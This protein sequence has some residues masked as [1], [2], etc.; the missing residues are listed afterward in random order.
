[1]RT[2]QLAPVAAVLAFSLTGCFAPGLE[3]GED[4]ASATQADESTNSLTANSL[5]ANSLTANSLTANSLTANALTDPAARAV[6]KYIVGCAL[7]AGQSIDL[8]IGGT[9]YHYDGQLGLAPS[10]GVDQGSSG[11]DGENRSACD[12]KCIEAVSSCVL[13]R[14]NYLGQM[15]PISV[16][17]AGLTAAPSEASAYPNMD[18]TYYGNI[19]TSPQI[20][21]ACLPP[22]VTQLTRVCGPSLNGCVVTSQ[23]PCDQVCGKMKSDGSYKHCSDAS[24]SAKFDR[25]IS[26]Y[27]Q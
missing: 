23:G 26:V 9:S 5:T 27:L 20:R 10:W 13:A 4:V 21:Y 25:S 6:L 12:S 7:P 15:V 8:V 17:G 19:F 11:D 14:V 18:G 2:F 22:G 24:A 3:D 16:R 1:M